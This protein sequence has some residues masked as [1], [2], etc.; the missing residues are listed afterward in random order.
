MIGLADANNFFATCESAFRPDWAGRPLVVASN[1]D[2]AV[3]SRSAEA[4][5]IGIPMGA[6]LF[7]LKGLIAK[8]NV[9]VCSSN[10]E[11]YGD[12]SNRMMSIMRELAPRLRVYSV[13]ECFFTS[14]GIQD[15]VAFGHQVRD[16]VRRSTGITLTIGFGPTRTLAK[17]ASKLGKRG[18]GVVDLATETSILD[19]LASMPVGDIWGIG[20]R[21]GEQ[22][23]EVGICTAADLRAMH[24]PTVRAR[25]GVVLERTVRELNGYAC[26]PFDLPDPARK[27]MMCSRSFGQKI[28][29][30][31]TM[32]QALASFTERAASRC[33][34]HGLNA[35]AVMVFLNTDPFNAG[36]Q[37]YCPSLTITLPHP[38][39]DTRVLL[40]AVR[41]LTER[42]YR[43]GFAFKRAG[44]A[45]LDLIE[46]NGQASLFSAD[47]PQDTALMSV[48][49]LINAK[50]G[51]G[52]AKMGVTTERKVPGWKGL[53]EHLSP[54]YSTRWE[55][56]P[57]CK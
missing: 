9:I 2:G 52:S 27:Q 37:Q 46:G 25:Y 14:T 1:N 42:M 50:Y 48:M 4:K 43:K 23:K 45:L 8:H 19:G 47:P 49:D 54:R 18:A 3:V 12:M 41:Q 57:V 35:Q 6:P 33:R 34:Q 24:A 56:I 30:I 11:L 38:S 17:A 21:W 53:S 22:L 55:D 29:D 10:Y 15:R 5:A 39:S 26:Q 20:R 44:V 13:D 32:H 28:V 7:K 31:G 51:R 40:G 16:T 36:A